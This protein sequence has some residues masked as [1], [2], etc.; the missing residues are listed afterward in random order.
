LNKKTAR[1]LSEMTLLAVYPVLAIINEVFFGVK[2]GKK[3][4]KKSNQK[5]R[6]KIF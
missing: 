4:E 3:K 2:I 5:K 6:K 1:R